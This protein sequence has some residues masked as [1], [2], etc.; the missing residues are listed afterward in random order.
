[1]LLKILGHE[2]GIFG[3]AIQWTL[4]PSKPNKNAIL[5]I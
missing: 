5:V 1:M 3:V 4:N 2:L